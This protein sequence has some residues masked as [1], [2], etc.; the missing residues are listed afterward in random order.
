[1]GTGGAYANWRESRFAGRVSNSF[2]NSGFDRLRKRERALVG[3]VGFFWRFQ[4]RIGKTHH[5]VRFNRVGGQRRGQLRFRER[6]FHLAGLEGEAPPFADD[7][8]RRREYFKM[9]L[10]DEHAIVNLRGGL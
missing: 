7:G 4:D 3:G 8:G 10:E 1:M 5:G 6:G 2:W 9:A